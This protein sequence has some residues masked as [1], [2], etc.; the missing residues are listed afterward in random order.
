MVISDQVGEYKRQDKL[1][2]TETLELVAFGDFRLIVGVC[3]ANLVLIDDNAIIVDFSEAVG[4][5]EV[6]P[7]DFIVEGDMVAFSQSTDPHVDVMNPGIVVHEDDIVVEDEDVDD[8]HGEL[9]EERHEEADEARRLRLFVVVV[10]LKE[11]TIEVLVR[12]INHTD[13][14]EIQTR[15]NTVP[16]DKFAEADRERINVLLGQMANHDE[17]GE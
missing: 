2:L 14:E 11:I 16:C 1:I 4:L 15:G 3:T 10:H 17:E 6:I 7:T 8:E 12:H 5:L 13:K 9:D